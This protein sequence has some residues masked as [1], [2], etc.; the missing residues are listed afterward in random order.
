MVQKTK[1]TSFI[2]DL[3]KNDLVMV[4]GG[5]YT[6][7]NAIMSQTVEDALS[8]GKKVALFVADYINNDK[9]LITEELN[10]KELL[11]I[12]RSINFITDDIDFSN[13]YSINRIAQEVGSRKDTDE[14]YDVVVITDAEELPELKNCRN[15]VE[16]AGMMRKVQK[17]FSVPLVFSMLL[18]KR[19]F[20]RFDYASNKD[21]LFYS[22][23]DF[24]DY[25]IRVDDDAKKGEYPLQV[26]ARFYDCRISKTDL[27]FFFSRNDSRLYLKDEHITDLY[28]KA[29]ALGLEKEDAVA[30]AC[31]WSVNKNESTGDKDDD[32]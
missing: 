23:R 32:I 11:S 8:S 25:L 10:N 30:Y 9:P 21:L 27:E 3:K 14:R 28:D 19:P 7:I 13:D 31:Y 5:S 2:P 26:K 4:S 1:Q 24:V 29:L 22:I 12:F 17:E 18:S 16:I 20:R 15:P 6:G